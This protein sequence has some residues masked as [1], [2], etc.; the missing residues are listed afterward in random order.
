MFPYKISSLH[1]LFR[2]TFHLQRVYAKII[3]CEWRN[4]SGCLE[5]ISLF[6]EYIFI[7]MKL[8]TRQ[9]KSMRPREYVCYSRGTSNVSKGTG[10]VRDVQIKD[11]CPCFFRAHR[12]C[13]IQQWMLPY[14]DKASVLGLPASPILQPD[15][16]LPHRATHIWRYLDSKH[17]ECWNGRELLLHGRQSQQTWLLQISWHENVWYVMTFLSWFN[18]FF[19]WK[20]GSSKRLKF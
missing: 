8:S 7:T 18:L 3:L 14:Y 1:L 10:I 4:G 11:N 20:T 5:Q 15:G 17:P 12:I 6:D 19:I 2:K 16:A 9:C 13:W